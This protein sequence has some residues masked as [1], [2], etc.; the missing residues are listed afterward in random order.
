MIVRESGPATA[1]ETSQTSQLAEQSAARSRRIS[2]LLI[3]IILMGSV[4]LC[5]TLTY[6]R[7]SGMIEANPLAYMVVTAGSASHLIAF[8]L[9]TMAVCCGAIL[10]ARAHAKAE[11]AS[12]VCA[13]VLLALTFHW[14]NYNRDVSSFTNDMAVLALSGGECEP[15][16][17]K[18]D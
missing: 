13:G 8:K 18:I 12:W 3:A 11:F 15:R 16:W 1:L 6:A 17:I 7:T 5:C 2:L 4:D 14:I 10:L 9:F